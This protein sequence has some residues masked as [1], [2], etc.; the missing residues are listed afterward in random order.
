MSWFFIALGAPFLWALVNISDQYLVKKYSIGEKGSGGL[1]LFSSL[2]GIFVAIF[3]GIFTMGIF[4]IPI[5]DK[6]LLILTGG[7]VILWVIIY[8]YTIEI[9]DISFIAPWFSVVPIFGYIL[10][11]VFLGET[12]NN[13][14]LIGSGIVLLG[15]FL[16]S[17]D[18]SLEEKY[19]FKWKP[20]LYMIITSFIIAVIGIIFKY[21][22]IVDRF[23]ISSFWEYFGLG[24]FGILIY[25]FIPKYRR[26]FLNMNRLGG[27]KIFILNIFSEFLTIIGSLLTNYAVLLAPVALVYLVGSFQPAI[28]L[29]FV[30]LGTKFFPKIITEKIHHQ[31]MI[32]KIIA[33]LIILIGSFILFI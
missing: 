5:M 11:Y 33:I 19:K 13:Q 9:E 15:V 23:W 21:V 2:I 22:T 18:F 24:V 30:I 17:I 25:F 32:P 6:F 29:L 1:V 7:L 10:G 4:E 3:I 27:I 16:I 31:I 26:E 14:Q 8:L 28:V 12:L 20:A